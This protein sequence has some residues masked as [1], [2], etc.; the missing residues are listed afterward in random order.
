[1]ASY[2][3]QRAGLPDRWRRRG[4]AY[5]QSRP[6]LGDFVIGLRQGDSYFR[7]KDERR[8]DRSFAT[9]EAAQCVVNRINAATHLTARYWTC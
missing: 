3:Y 5:V 4:E 7:L 2:Q 9:R 6:L 8:E 1:M